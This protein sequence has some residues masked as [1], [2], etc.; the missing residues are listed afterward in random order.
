MKDEAQP[1]IPKLAKV[2]HSE[3]V[4]P[5]SHPCSIYLYLYDFD[6]EAT[7][8]LSMM[9]IQPNTERVQVDK[10][11]VTDFSAL[12]QGVEAT[13]KEDQVSS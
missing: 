3:E 9:M 10:V 12:I 2:E 1:F 13:V 4:S 7:H 5:V 6:M 8:T 11:K